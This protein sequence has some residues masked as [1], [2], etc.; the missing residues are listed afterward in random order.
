MESYEKYSDEQLLKFREQICGT[1]E[2]E[3]ITEFLINKYKILVLRKAKQMFLLG[4]EKD[5]LIQEGMIGLFKAVREYDSDKN[6]EFKYFANLCIT[7]QL[8]TAV[9]VSQRKKHQPLNSYISFYDSTGYQNFNGDNR[10]RSLE[11]TLE[12]DVNRNPEELWIDR[13]NLNDLEEVMEENLSS[14][15]KMVVEY[16]IEGMSYQNIALQL[17]KTPKSIDNAMQRIKRKLKKAIEKINKR[18]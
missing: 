5:D 14:L 9:S 16:Y 12:S 13:E 1:K 11:E 17:N 6:I 7:R 4:G 18:S 3:E 15:E 8:Y 2:E 10:E